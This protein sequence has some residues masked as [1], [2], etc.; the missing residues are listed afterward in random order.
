[1]SFKNRRLFLLILL[2][3]IQLRGFSQDKIIDVSYVENPDLTVDI[4]YTKRVPGSFHLSLF[5]TNL[6]NSNSGGIDRILKSDG[7][8]LIKLRP[9]NANQ[10][11]RFGY[12]VS[13]IRGKP[14][15][16]HDSEV[17]YLLPFRK[18]TEV[19]VELQKDLSAQLFNTYTSKDWKVFEFVVDEV[20]TIFN[21]RK[22]MIVDLKEEYKVDT[23]GHYILSSRQNFVLVEHDDGTFS[24]YRGFGQN[25]IDVALG[26][27]VYPQTPLGV[28]AN[29]GG[30]EFRLSYATYGRI[31][32]KS[33]IAFKALRKSGVLEFYDPPFMTDQGKSVLENNSTYT[34][35]YSEAEIIQELSKKELKRRKKAKSN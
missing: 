3:L 8:L 31:E 1:M 7:G 16:K 24:Y 20:D 4:F 26:E 14:N 6:N 12:Q 15:P 27:I 17:T 18:K 2:S 35:D 10:G 28:I 9:T 32:G 30:K 5:F 33:D 11:I 22:G 34:V 29:T 25:Q 21:S 13:Y 23:I 19:T